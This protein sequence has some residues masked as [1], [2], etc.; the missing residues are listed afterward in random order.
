[1]ADPQAAPDFRKL[2]GHQIGSLSNESLRAL[3][4]HALGLLNKDTQENQL[5]YYKPTNARSAKI[6]DSKA[7]VVGIGG[8]N[9]SSKTETAL[10]EMIMCATGI[11]PDS[12]K[13]LATKY[14]GPLNCRVV[15]ESLTTV[16]HPIILPK[17][18]WYKWTGLDRPGG[19]RGHWGWIPRFSLKDGSWEKS[20]SEKLRT[21]T[22][23]ARDPATG[24]IDGE[25]T[26]QFMSSDQDPSDFASGDFHLILHD[27]PPTQAIWTENEARTMRVNGRMLLAMTWPDDP[28]IP[29]DWI[30][31]KVYEPGQA[32]PNR[33]PDIEWIELWTTENPHL[34]QEAIRAQMSRWSHERQQV[35]IFG[36]N[37]RFS[38]RVHP[39]FGD[40]TQT[41]SPAAHKVV[42]PVEGKCPVTGSRD[43][44]EFSHVGEFEHSRDWPV[45]FL[46]DPHPRKPHMF[47]WCQV[48]PM[49]D[50]WVLDDGECSG[51]PAEVARQ[52]KQ[53]ELDMGY[54][55]V[56]RIG[57]PNM[58]RSPAGT[59]R[60]V[61]WEDEFSSA[62]LPIELAN[63]IDV[64]RERLNAYLQPDTHTLRPRIVFHR[65]AER[66]IFQL[67]RYTWDEYRQRDERDQK[68]KPRQK[69]DDY[70]TLLK[71]L[72]NDEPTFRLL[73]HGA[74]I[75]NAG[76]RSRAYG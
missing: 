56:R 25:S 27:E 5:V 1:M 74:P 71:Y 51:D 52:V 16:L 19:A 50:Y 66:T 10:V 69:Y 67:K 70:P 59:R 58:L 73:V 37:L 43:L 40:F 45:V 14:R 35:R 20:W 48:D 64:G 68:Q 65:R 12:V 57:D 47:L 63:D 3:A 24:R 72:M 39:L 4:G 44:I 42:Q 49:D 26:I 11:F 55:V 21:L 60:E 22:I 13:H 23:V 75:I 38:N 7:R 17:L 6:H 54:R 2:V 36:G 30:F 9:G 28:S 53:H 62:G 18:Q 32:G 76:R 33:H 29:V 61:N 41:W 8:G 31:D 46:L 34:D 15:C